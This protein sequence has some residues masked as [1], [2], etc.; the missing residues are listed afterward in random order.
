MCARRLRIRRHELP[1]WVE[2]RLFVSTSFRPGAAR[3]CPGCERHRANRRNADA[4]QL[5][6]LPRLAYSVV[7]VRDLADLHIRAMLDPIADGQRYLGVAS[8]VSMADIARFLK[9]GLGAPTNRVPSRELPGWVVRITGLFDS[10]VRGQ[11]F[12]L[13]RE[14]KGSSQK[15]FSQLG[16]TTRP[17]DQTI[18][19]TATSLA[20][21]GGLE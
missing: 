8:F 14:R 10:A 12:E 9:K 16:W 5:P 6:G 13:G 1:L 15:A 7:D 3:A 20:A 19:D 17:I 21:V 4:R 11:P 18:V 2:G